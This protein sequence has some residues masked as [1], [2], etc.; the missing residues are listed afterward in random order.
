VAAPPLMTDSLMI[1]LG[2]KARWAHGRDFSESS[3]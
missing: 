3:F 1:K 2:A